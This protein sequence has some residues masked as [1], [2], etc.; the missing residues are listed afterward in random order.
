MLGKVLIKKGAMALIYFV[1]ALCVELITFAFL[2]LGTPVYIIFDLAIIFLLSALVFIIPGIKG[3]IVVAAIFLTV[4]CVISF[5]NSILFNVDGA[6]FSIEMIQV[7]GEGIAAFDSNFINVPFLFIL[8]GIIS[9]FIT[10]LILIHKFIKTKNEYKMS[11]ILIL[12]GIFSFV[13]VFSF[14]LYK[15]Q[16]TALRPLAQN[17]GNVFL[18]DSMLYDTLELKYEA[19]KKFGSFGFYYKSI[20][21]SL[22]SDAITEDDVE[23]LI[24]Y[25]KYSEG[26]K[27]EAS[28]YHGISE[29]NNVIMIMCESLEWYAISNDL[30]PNLYNLKYNNIYNDKF[31]SNNKTNVSEG[32]AILGNYPKTTGFADGLSAAE[33]TNSGFTV[34]YSLP[35]VLKTEGYTS[36]Y[37][38]DYL[39]TFYGR[40]SSHTNIFGFDNFTDMYDMGN[41]DKY[42]NYVPNLTKGFG[43]WIKDSQMFETCLYDI[44]P[45]NGT[46]FFSYITTVSMHGPYNGNSRFSEYIDDIDNY[47]LSHSSLPN[48]DF[49]NFS[50]KDKEHIKNYVA[51]AMDLDKG[52]GIL[53]DRL[54]T[55]NLIENTTVVI[56]SDHWAYYQNLNFYAKGLSKT[57]LYNPELYRVPFIM[58]DKKLQAEITD[59]EHLETDYYNLD[60]YMSAHDI[61]PTVLDTLGYTYN[62][63]IMLGK[64]V[65]LDDIPYSCL[66]S[67]L[68][69]FYNDRLFTY[70]GVDY[71]YEANGVTEKER[72]DFL[73]YL[74][75]FINKQ[76]Y[77]ELIYKLKDSNIQFSF[78]DI[79][80]VEKTI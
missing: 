80:T 1:F 76:S 30:T 32:F 57:Q 42:D 19:L 63:K 29:G 52:I 51:A 25:L 65:L 68:S 49:S 8:L 69:G 70:N 39:G 10:I 22:S 28:Y 27:S 17:A 31:Y 67:F 5:L 41:K 47:L 53:M 18:D 34:P 37:F 4:Q 55:T 73:N 58:V 43:D 16:E 26:D 2:R 38:H 36:S 62:K 71:L 46:N 66:V 21:N 78:D 74:V 54:E 59:R 35:N 45:N 12:V 20:Q 44:A 9:A 23:K 61:L 72:E 48:M 7:G 13:Q 50:S 56:F 64:S 33:I 3:Q 14:G 15:I 77:I 75:D 24:E 6:I 60:T 79:F 11:F 40:S